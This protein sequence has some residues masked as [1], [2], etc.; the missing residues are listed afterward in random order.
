MVFVAL[1]NST[2]NEKFLLEEIK[3]FFLII[4]KKLNA[5]SFLIQNLVLINWK[6]RRRLIEGISVRRSEWRS[7]SRS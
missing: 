5:K 3:F 6:I 4:N 7:W 1:K 2:K